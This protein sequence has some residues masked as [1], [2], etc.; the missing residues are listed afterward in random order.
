MEEIRRASRLEKEKSVTALESDWR[1]LEQSI[2]FFL[3]STEH[4]WSLFHLT[5]FPKSGMHKGQRV[6]DRGN[7][8]KC[9]NRP[10]SPNHCSG[11]W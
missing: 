9:A 7:D 10:A 8:T 5:S 6:E 2:Y 4:F 11:E 1:E 3:H